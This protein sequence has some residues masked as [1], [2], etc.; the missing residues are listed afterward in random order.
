VQLKQNLELA[1]GVLQQY[2]S[3]LS[4]DACFAFSPPYESPRGRRRPAI[5]S[6]SSRLGNPSRR[7]HLSALTFPACPVLKH[8][9]RLTHC[10]WLVPWP[11]LILAR[12]QGWQGCAALL[13]TSLLSKR[14][15]RPWSWMPCHSLA[16][17]GW[18]QRRASFL[19]PQQQ[20]AT[21]N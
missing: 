6:Q 13:D 5:L 18:S 3:R 14:S 16:C 8:H 2:V 10:H 9:D 4:C 20:V 21:S 15:L 11:R 17:P 1:I 12:A 19:N 7:L